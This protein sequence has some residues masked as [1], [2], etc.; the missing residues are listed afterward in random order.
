MILIQFSS[1]SSGHSARD[2]YLYQLQRSYELR[3]IFA[4]LDLLLL[5]PHRL[6]PS[7]LFTPLSLPS[8]LFLLLLLLALSSLFLFLSARQLLLSHLFERHHVCLP[9]LELI[10]LLEP[11]QYAY[12]HQMVADLDT[13]SPLRIVYLCEVPKLLDDLSHFLHHFFVLELV[14]VS[15]LEVKCPTFLLALRHF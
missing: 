2:D 8:L 13:N 10:V 15:A 7:S 6:L 9:Q 12:T 1:H 4:H 5:E 14:V 3:I 11:L